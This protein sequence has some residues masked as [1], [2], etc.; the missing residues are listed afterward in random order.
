MTDVKKS[1]TVN[2]GSMATL[3]YILLRL[4]TNILL[5]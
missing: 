4:E 5:C 3:I 1:K 2:F